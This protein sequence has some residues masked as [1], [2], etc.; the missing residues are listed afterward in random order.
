MQAIQDMVVLLLNDSTKLFVLANSTISKKTESSTPRELSAVKYVLQSFGHI[1]AN[2]SIQVNK[3]NIGACRILSVGSS[4]KHL[5]SLVVD[6]FKHCVKFNINLQPNW[7][8][9]EMNQISDFYSIMTLIIGLLT[10]TI[11]RQNDSVQSFIVQTLNL[12]IGKER[13]I[14]YALQSL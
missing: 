7:V 1:I 14:F 9:R 11:K 5:Q 4:K 12:L 10:I 3:D 13:I 8:P 2:E 6:V